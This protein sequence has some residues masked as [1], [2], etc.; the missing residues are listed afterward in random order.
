MY[1]SKCLDKL[2]KFGN[3][4]QIEKN[5]GKPQLYRLE[6]GY[7]S[8]SLQVQEYFFKSKHFWLNRMPSLSPNLVIETGI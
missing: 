5:F 8:N 2:G 7:L 3:I 4:C 6:V 1:I